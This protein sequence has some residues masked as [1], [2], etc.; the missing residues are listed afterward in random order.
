MTI[1]EK[2][3]QKALLLLEHQEAK[4]DLV[5]L[6]EKIHRTADAYLN[7]GKFLKS[8]TS[9]NDTGNAEREAIRMC[10]EYSELCRLESVAETLSEVVSS[11]DR[12][13]ELSLRKASLGI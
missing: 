2:R 10:E 1:G 9:A 8:V 11:R 4:D 5:N 3:T 7:I 6:L 12:V 13:K